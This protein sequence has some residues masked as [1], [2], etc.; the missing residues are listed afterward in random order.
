MILYNELSVWS[1]ILK[2]EVDD[3]DHV[4]SGNIAVSVRARA[5]KKERECS[6]SLS[7]SLFFSTRSG[8]WTRTGITAHWILSPACLPF[9]HPGKGQR[10][11]TSFQSLR[12]V[13]SPTSWLL[14]KN[15]H[16]VFFYAHPYHPGDSMSESLRVGKSEGLKVWRSE[17]L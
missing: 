10:K 16:R 17:S 2:R 12:M 7:L 5:W 3:P 14:A 11:N 13:G 15:T 4:I 8:T 1:R 9:H 6:L